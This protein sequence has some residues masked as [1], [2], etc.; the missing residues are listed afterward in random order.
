MSLYRGS[1]MFYAA[2]GGEREP[3][4]GGRAQP[5]ADSSCAP[6]GGAHQSDR[7]PWEHDVHHEEGQHGPH[8]SPSRLLQQPAPDGGG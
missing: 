3:G 6:A 1:N 7:L 8:G 5:A 2:R 4:P